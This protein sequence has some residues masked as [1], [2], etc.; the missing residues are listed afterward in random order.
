MQ[1]RLPYKFDYRE[2]QKDLFAAAAKDFLRLYIIWHRRAGKDLSCFNVLLIK[3][4]ERRGLYWHMLPQFN[5]AR[6]AIWQGMTKDGRRFLDYIPR[7]LVKAI[8]NVEMKIELINGSIIQVVGSDNIDALVGANPVGVVLS[9]YA[10]TNPKAWGLIE[11]ILIE[12]GGW[13]LFNTTPR[14]KNHAYDLWI[15]ALE[16]EKWFTQKLT[17]NDTGVVDLDFIDELRKM[18]TDEET[19]QQ[20][21]Y[22]SFE[23]SLQGAY[24]ASQIRDLENE[25]KISNVP[26]EGQYEVDC[27]L[28]IGIR[29]STS[30]WFEQKVGYEHRIIDYL[31]HNGEGVEYYVRE[32]KNKNYNYGVIYLPH[33]AAAKQFATGK[34]ILEQFE[35][36]W[37]GQRFAVLPRT[38]SV[39]ADIS[40]VRGFLRKCV[41]DKGRCEDGLNALKSYRKKWDDKKNCY[42]DRPYHDWASH[43][44]DAFRYLATNNVDE[45]NLVAG[46]DDF[47]RALRSRWRRESF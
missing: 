37:A 39:N 17:I 35:S 23:G 46:S 11:P 44:A 43:G 36:M 28:D 25:G 30:I 9:E 3:A 27:Y 42:D 16:N 24:Y 22:C 4:M 40:V 33:D 32:L 26:Y 19:I 15:K 47:T 2:Y 20:E 13:A 18:G 7:E 14:G 5:Q 41:F 38:G 8:N 45:K 6:R 12:N 29:D 31:Q 1:I 21:Y 34:S 10:L